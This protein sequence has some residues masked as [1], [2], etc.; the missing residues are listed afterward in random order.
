MTEKEPEFIFEVGEIALDMFN[1]EVK[2]LKK[3]RRPAEWRYR[4][5]YLTQRTKFAG[6]FGTFN[7]EWILETVLTKIIP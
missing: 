5:Q 4:N 6:L 7:E 3:A 1:N 2:I